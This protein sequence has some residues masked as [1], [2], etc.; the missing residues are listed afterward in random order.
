MLHASS[1]HSTR[2]HDACH[3]SG[4]LCIQGYTYIH[5]YHNSLPN[6]KIRSTVRT[7]LMQRRTCNHRTLVY[8]G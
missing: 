4:I 6:V 2:I 1:T 8:E 7:Y 5:V 3:M